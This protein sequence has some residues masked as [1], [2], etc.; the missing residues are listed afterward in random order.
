M[1]F[2]DNFSYLEHRILDK[3]IQELENTEIYYTD[4]IK[5]DSIKIKNLNNNDQ[6]EKYAREKY[7]MK[8]E[9]EDI[10]LIEFEED[11]E[12]KTTN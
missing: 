2:L 3:E 6:I 4:E 12:V 8:R 7:F 1:I 9:N 10:Y 11:Q 5:K